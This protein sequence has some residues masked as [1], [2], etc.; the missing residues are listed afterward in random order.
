MFL[1]SLDDRNK[2]SPLVT[3][4]NWWLRQLETFMGEVWILQVYPFCSDTVINR[5][6]W[7]TVFLQ[8]VKSLT[9]N[10]NF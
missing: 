5:L 3:G 9:Q 4:I 10:E 7:G 2:T 6:F 1:Q 8:V